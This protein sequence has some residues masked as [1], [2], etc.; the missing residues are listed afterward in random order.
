MLKLDSILPH[1][2]DELSSAHFIGLNPSSTDDDGNITLH[3]GGVLAKLIQAVAQ[4]SGRE[5]QFFQFLLGHSASR[6]K[7]IL[8]GSPKELNE[9]VRDYEIR[10][11][12]LAFKHKNADDDL[13]WND[14]G[15]TVNKIFQYK[16]YRESELC[17]NH[18][19][20]LGLKDAM[21]CPYCNLDHISLV[22][23]NTPIEKIQA[24]LD[25]D[26]FFPHSK[27]PFLGISLYN[28]IP[29]CRNCNEV[30][31]K[32]KPFLMHTHIHPYHLD[33]DDLFE[34]TL[35]SPYVYKQP[36]HDVQITYKNRSDFPANSLN[37]LKI[38]E[39]YQAHRRELI[40]TIDFFYKRPINNYHQVFGEDA[41]T[42]RQEVFEVAG[43]PVDRADLINHSL[44]KLKRDILLAAGLYY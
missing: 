7:V 11:P 23:H 32:R 2:L 8:I 42:E 25:L 1:T 26:H 13:V 15:K 43:V 38:I 3:P 9:V 17:T 27:Y 12:G 39:R 33:F 41:S 19:I 6:L 37:D 34:F 40:R 18:L 44:G 28:L 21:P 24:L 20:G 30:Y 22:E 36:Y 4:H 16:K 5:K 35:S 10:F 14:L 29:T 31:K